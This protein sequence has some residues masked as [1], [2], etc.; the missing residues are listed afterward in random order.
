MR[1]SIVTLFI[2]TSSSFLYSGIVKDERLIA[3][4][5]ENLE[6]K[7]S[8]QALVKIEEM[9]HLAKITPKEIDR[10][11]V[12]N[13]PGSFTGVRIGVT[14]A[15]TYAWALKKEIIPIRSLEAMAVSTKENKL[16]VSF[17]DARR[18]YVFAGVYDKDNQVVLENQY[19]E[20]SKL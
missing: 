1:S 6:K 7:L 17:I 16:K 19:I 3:E 5:K 11:V 13:G 9:F 18:G 4:V 14:I 8:E 10:I 12:V 2:D 20:L 15:K